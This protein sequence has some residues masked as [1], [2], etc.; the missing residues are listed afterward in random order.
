M[1]ILETKSIKKS[2]GGVKALVD[3]TFSCAQGEIVGLLGANGSGKTT[4]SKVIMGL[5]HSDGGEILVNGEPT[6]FKAP[7]DAMRKGIVM[8]HQQLSL[9]PD[10]TVWE[11]INIGH[12]PKTGS[13]FLDDGAARAKAAQVVEL[14]SPGLSLD[15]K[16]KTLLP[17][18]QQLVEIAKALSKGGQ[19]LILDEPTSAL[20][21][22]QVNRLFEILRQL[23][24]QG[25]T[26][27]FISHRLGEVLEIC[28]YVVVFRNGANV[29]TVIFARDGKDEERI[30]SLITGKEE[31]VKPGSVNSRSQFEEA[32]LEV[33]DLSA[34]NLHDINF[35][36]HKGE[37]IGIGGLQGQG[38]EDLLLVLSGLIHS[39]KGEIKI[40]GK[41]VKFKHPS[42]AIRTGVVLVPGDR[43][44]EG[45]F[46]N[47]SLFMNVIY[48]RFGLKGNWLIPFKRYRS[49]VSEVVSSLAI[50][51]ENIETELQ[52][53]SGGNQQKVVVGKWLPL[54]PNVL[55]LSDPAKGVDVQAK[56]E[57]YELVGNLARQ[58]T[59]VILYASDN[60][61][62]VSHCDRVF[63]LYEGQIVEELQ[64]EDLTEDNLVA[65]SLRATVKQENKGYDT[66]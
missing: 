23:K 19:L 61:E 55:L 49:E 8:V 51:T 48:A 45:L 57:L 22:T 46:L 20:E 1:N 5:L 12:E 59:S 37:I 60:E 28:D 66:Q 34:G 18:E 33:K 7:I 4:F 64:G 32:R 56:K 50:K 27:I 47:H 39:E 16:V 11:N 15:R 65:A 41:S 42:D 29:G 53:L 31:A 44:K 24:S 58:E 9:I 62:L 36:V 17:S 6:H 63:I 40:D 30:V 26:I 2:F 3:G 35:V 38:Q 21:Q 52:N 13:G 25:T 54:N 43:Q 10:L 14:L